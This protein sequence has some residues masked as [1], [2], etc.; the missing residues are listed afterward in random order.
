MASYLIPQ[1]QAWFKFISRHHTDLLETIADVQ[2]N[3]RRPDICCLCGSEEYAD[4]FRSGE[5][6]PEDTVLTLRLCPE[7]KKNR[8]EA[9]GESFLPIPENS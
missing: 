1:S 9:N 2:A 7:C 6:G 4:Y 3:E 5:N 8:E